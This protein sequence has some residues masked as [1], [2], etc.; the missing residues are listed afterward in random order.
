ML[1]SIDLP[2][3]ALATRRRGCLA[4]QGVR[5]ECAKWI[6]TALTKKRQFRIDTTIKV[7]WAIVVLPANDGGG[8]VSVQTVKASLTILFLARQSSSC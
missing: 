4:G 3:R 1:V 7:H 5:K 2:L 6:L 8:R